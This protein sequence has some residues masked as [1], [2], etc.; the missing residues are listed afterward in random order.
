[1]ARFLRQEPATDAVLGAGYDPLTNRD[2]RRRVAVQVCTPSRAAMKGGAPVSW[3]DAM[4]CMCVRMGPD[5]P[6]MWT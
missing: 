1:M 6:C 3:V 2:V 4:W 5:H